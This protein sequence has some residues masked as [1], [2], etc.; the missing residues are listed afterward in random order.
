V[1]D[2]EAAHLQLF[3]PVAGQHRAFGGSLG[4]GLPVH[5][6]AEQEAP[7]RRIRGHGR[8]G[9]LQRD[10]QVVQVQLGRPAGVLPVLR[11]QG[12]DGLLAHAREATFVATQPVAQRKQRVVASPG[13]V[14]PTFQCGD[15]EAHVQARVGVTPRLGR[16]DQ[17]RIAQPSRLGG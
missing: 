13:R 4:A 9:G 2:F 14:V 6:L 16:Q 3:E 5:A 1:L 15:A 10:A 8:A 12:G 11:R 17:Q 7:Y